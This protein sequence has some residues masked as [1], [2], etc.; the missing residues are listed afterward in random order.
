MDTPKESASQV[1]NSGGLP[2]SCRLI[3]KNELRDR[4]GGIPNS[5][6]YRMIGDKLLPPAIHLAGGRSSYWLES[7]VDGAIER[8]V[9]Q[10]R[11]GQQ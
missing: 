3:R 6:L 7:E 11:R 1:G 4:L 5:T 10:A 8:L 9:E 2:A